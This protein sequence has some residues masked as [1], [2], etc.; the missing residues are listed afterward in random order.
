[1]H[2]VACVT[3][4]NF[5]FHLSRI[6]VT[7]LIPLLY[8]FC[9]HGYVYAAY[10][11]QMLAEIMTPVDTGFGTY[12]PYL[13]NISSPSV[14]IYTISA[15]F[16]NVSNF[17]KF[18]FSENDKLSL[19]QN[20]F[21]AKPSQY[22]QI[23]DIYNECK[24]NEIPIFVSV[25]SML[26][27]FH[28][29]YD[30]AL[31]ILEVQKFYPTL[32]SL[33]AEMMG[34]TD[35]QYRSATDAT[36][37]EMAR[38][39]LAY[40]AV[41][42]K[43][44]DPA[45]AV[46]SD[47]AAEV[48]AELNLIEKHSGFAESP[49]FG[50]LEDYSQ[51]VPRG[52]YTRNEVLKKYF[53]SMMWYGRMMFRLRPT[54]AEQGYRETLQA[55]LIVQAMHNN[56]FKCDKCANSA[57]S[58]WETIY[59]PTTFFVGKT[60]DL[61]IY[62]YTNLM[63]EVYGE[64]FATLPVDSF[65]DNTK[66]SKF[67][68]KALSLHNP[69]INSSFVLDWEQAQS[70]TPVTKGFRFMGQR[71]IPDS[72][73]FQQLVYDKVTKYTGTGDPFT[74]IDSIIGPVKGFPRGLEVFAVLGSTRA[75][76]ILVN[77][78]DTEYEKYFDRMNKLKLEFSL[79]PSS[80]WVQN[81]YWNWLYVLMPLLFE[82]G[83][84]FPIFMQ[85]TAWMDKELT[86]ALGSWVELRHD[87]LLYAKQ[88]YTIVA[89]AYPPGA[90]LPTGI[91]RGY[92]EPNPWVYARLAALAKFMRLGLEK[93]GLLLP[94]FRN[95]LIDFE[96]LQLALKTI[97]EKELTNQPLTLDEYVLICNIGDTLEKLLTFPPETAGQI[98]N[99]TDDEL[100]VI[101]D[102]HTDP[103]TGQCL[104]EGIG[105]P[106]DIYVIV[107]DADEIKVTRGAMFSYYE[108]KQPM[109][110]RLTDEEWQ[111]ML[112]GY[113][114]PR[115][116]NWNS[117]FIDLDQGFTLL[118]LAHN[119]SQSQGETPNTNT[120]SATGVI[121]SGGGVLTLNINGVGVAQIVVSSGVLTQYTTFT[122]AEEVVSSAPGVVLDDIED[123]TY[124]QRPLSVYNFSSSPPLLY[125]QISGSSVVKIILSYSDVDNDGIVDGTGI[126]EDK[127]R[128][129]WCDNSSGCVSCWHY[130]RA[131]V[132]DYVNNKI[133]ASVSQLGLFG[134]FPVVKKTTTTITSDSLDN[135][136][137]YPNP[138]K[139][140]DTG[141]VFAKLTSN[142]II[143]IYTISGEL[144]DV[145]EETDNDGVALWSLVNRN[146]ASGIYIYVITNRLGQKKVG[147]FA[148]IR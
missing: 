32:V 3:K 95:K 107:K 74:K 109:S 15:D 43:L 126:S 79:L 10:T 103:N 65:A 127:L 84:G 111:E 14:D 26:H 64:N 115:L 60:D 27:T 102:V 117:S 129:L 8:S 50:Y 92:V 4:R 2:G 68:D 112:K 18:T 101:A 125:S 80:V 23:Y 123:N 69:L 55:L 78:G 28:I 118:G 42:A 91:V 38:R 85:N 7:F 119:F 36:V 135:V 31:R 40:F 21:V 142:A 58:S 105:Y 63:R 67:I 81:L 39:N 66:L 46:P 87:T 44:L 146:L 75:L 104:E 62:D 61:N 34:Y 128:L 86:T 77:E 76:N 12:E 89:T 143:K 121:G 30:Y 52:H 100:A 9:I 124:S 145:I 132:P 47:V 41:A 51:Y 96:S 73:I 53:K 141:I 137:T 131:Q 93:Y 130:V 134:L 139:P 120:N 54:D 136:Y 122:I 33:T 37:R 144:V 106:L 19:R 140:G 13:V 56:W 6:I 90:N 148:V 20:Y 35:R 16:S 116:P 99:D 45:V 82:K 97:A 133:S 94:E 113:N 88:S 98:E 22:K 57:I 114:P 17:S 110:N 138:A 108:F 59:N 147:K 83:T 71:F 49:I 48:S 72:Y 29:L 11:P 70:V 25:D 1:M 24:K 5:L